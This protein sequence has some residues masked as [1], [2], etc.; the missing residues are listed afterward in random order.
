[1]WKN[2]F[3]SSKEAEVSFRYCS[4][5]SSKSCLKLESYGS[6]SQSIQCD[7]PL[8][9]ITSTQQGGLLGILGIEVPEA[10]L[11]ACCSLC[12]VL[13]R[14]VRLLEEVENEWDR[15]EEEGENLVEDDGKGEDGL[16]TCKGLKTDSW[17]G[18]ILSSILLIVQSMN[19]MVVDENVCQ[20]KEWVCQMFEG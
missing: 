5:K 3:S 6:L 14:E 11:L 12:H 4:Q 17:E 8:P 2:T 16:C 19:S 13:Q 9:I 18:V 10:S 15:E 1:M 20:F 7:E